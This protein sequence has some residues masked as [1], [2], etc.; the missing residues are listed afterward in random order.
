MNS[1]RYRVAIIEDNPLYVMTLQKHFEWLNVFDVIT[2]GNGKDAILYLAKEEN[3]VDAIILDYELPEMTG[4][5]IAEILHKYPHLRDVPVMIVTAHSSLEA[6]VEA[7]EA[8]VNMTFRKKS[9][10]ASEIVQHTKTLIEL[11]E[12]IEWLK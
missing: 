4:D 9:T 11:N 8:G 5:K 3:K 10:V 7:S 6:I 12:A 2:F 1:R